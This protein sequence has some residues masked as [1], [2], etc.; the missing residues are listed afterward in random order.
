MFQLPFDDFPNL[1]N[2]SS[3]RFVSFL[4]L[5]PTIYQGDILV[6]FFIDG[7]GNAV[8]YF[9]DFACYCYLVFR[10]LTNEAKELDDLVWN[11]ASAMIYT[12]TLGK[13]SFPD[14]LYIWTLW[15]T[16]MWWCSVLF[17]INTL[18][19]LDWYTMTVMDWYPWSPQSIF[20]ESSR[21]RL[22]I[23]IRDIPRRTHIN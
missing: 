20:V 16:Q 6:L 3:C 13:I 7:D 21:D 8:H 22:L 23:C 2:I 19:I 5:P 12:D 11:H 17:C 9:N 18:G 15:C 1:R 4:V 10:L 14:G